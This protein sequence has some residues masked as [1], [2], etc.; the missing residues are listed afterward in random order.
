MEN[1]VLAQQ[2]E[3]FGPSRQQLLGLERG[4]QPGSDQVPG[5]LFGILRQRR[6]PLEVVGQVLVLQELAAAQKV[7][8]G[9]AVKSGDALA[10]LDTTILEFQ[11]AQA[12]AA[13]SLAQARLKQTQTPASEESQA[14]ALAAV[15]AAEAQFAR[16]SAGPNKDELTMA[17]ANV[18]RAKF[19]VDQA[20]AGYDKAG[21]ASNPNAGLL[22][23]SVGLQQATAG[24]ETSPGSAAAR[25]P[26]RAR[27]FL[28]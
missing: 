8:E 2:E 14:A 25:F 6:R 18:D 13:V 10:S 22:P 23:T 21:G 11:I 5:S 24:Y 27:I 1:L 16:V 28:I 20:Q 4:D 15:K 12:E 9:A 3:T 7:Q 19:L 26:G 17:K